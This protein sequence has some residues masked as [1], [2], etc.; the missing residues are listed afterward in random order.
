MAG[1][2]CCDQ[3][4]LWNKWTADRHVVGPRSLRDQICG[5]A[6]IRASSSGSTAATGR[7]LPTV[8]RRVPRHRSAARVDRTRRLVGDRRSEGSVT[9]QRRE[10]DGPVRIRAAVVLAAP[11]PR[12]AARRLHHRD[13]SW[14]RGAA[15][16][17]P[18]RHA[19]AEHTSGPWTRVWNFHAGGGAIQDDRQVHRPRSKRATARPNSADD[20]ARKAQ[21]LTYEGQR[22]MFEAYARN[23]YTATGV[24][25]WML[26]NAWPSIIWHLYDYYLRPARRL[27][28]HQEGVRA[29]ARAVLVRRSLDRAREQHPIAGHGL[30]VSASVLDFDLK[31]RFSR[32][33]DVDL[34]AD[35]VVRA[36]SLPEVD[37]LTNDLLS[38]T[39]GRR[40]RQGGEHELLL[41][42]DAGGSAGL[43][44]DGMVLHPNHPSRR[45]RQCWRG[46]RDDGHGVAGAAR[47]R[48]GRAGENTGS[49]LAFQVHLKLVDPKTQE[50]ICRCS[51]R[52][53]TSRCCRASGGQSG[54][55][56]PPG[57]CPGDGGRMESSSA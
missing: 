16:R 37:G 47:R 14:R 29:G 27:F 10:D 32:Q 2:C 45:S 23:K 17:E 41:A 19:A 51:G 9:G 28:R 52:T 54:F 8:E 39:D 38:E 13:Q 48:R 40:R 24:I 49:A 33:A 11:T 44:E 26:N 7:R 31:Q 55:R 25:Q 1:W 56:C 42:L 46:C 12:T 4:E 43:V 18:A 5:C 35:A 34:P 50:S 22:A 36:F 30:R 53:I 20:Y 57:R 3:W 21:A 15:H 6:R